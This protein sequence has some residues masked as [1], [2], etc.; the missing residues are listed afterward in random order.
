MPIYIYENIKT[1]KVWEE[2]LPYEDRNNPVNKNVIRIPAAT[3]MFRILDSN[4][5][6]IRDRLGSMAQQGYKERD[7]LEKKG[8]IK[9]SNAEKESREKRQQKRKWV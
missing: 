1:G 9:V 8:L 6:K 3:A 5:N 2:N 7:T 4:E